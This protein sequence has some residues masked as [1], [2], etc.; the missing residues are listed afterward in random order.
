MHA[1]VIDTEWG[2]HAAYQYALLHPNS[3]LLLPVMYITQRMRYKYT[4]LKC[5]TLCSLRPCVGRLAQ[6]SVSGSVAIHTYPI[7]CHS[8]AHHMH[9]THGN[10]THLYR[11]VLLV[12]CCLLRCTAHT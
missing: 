4:V 8:V 9:Y 2:L 10:T 7:P 1:C 3:Y 5:V 6:S 12:V 11:I